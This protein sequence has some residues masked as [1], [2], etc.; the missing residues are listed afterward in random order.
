MQ[1]VVHAW[2]LNHLTAKYGRESIL[3]IGEDL[4]EILPCTVCSFLA[5]AHPVAIYLQCAARAHLVSAAG[6]K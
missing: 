4:T 5:L 3:K 1:G 6:L 2:I